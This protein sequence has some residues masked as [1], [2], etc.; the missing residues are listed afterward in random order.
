LSLSETHDLTALSLFFRY[1]FLLPSVDRSILHWASRHRSPHM[2]PL[3]SEFPSPEDPPLSALSSF[4]TLYP[5]HP[6]STTSPLLR[7]FPSPFEKKTSFF[8]STFPFFRTVPCEGCFSL[9]SP[10]F[11]HSPPPPPPVDFPAEPPNILRLPL[12]SFFF[13]LGSKHCPLTFPP[14]FDFYSFV[15]I[16]QRNVAQS[17]LLFLFTK[18]TWGPLPLSSLVFCLWLPYLLSLQFTSRFSG[19]VFS[20]FQPL[21]YPRAGEWP[22]SRVLP[23]SRFLFNPIRLSASD[24]GTV[25]LL[26]GLERCFVS[27][28]PA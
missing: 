22:F 23:L 19:P 20:I 11:F 5:C 15:M 8:F 17:S 26:M 12:K 10:P 1:F 9:W 7:S 3:F 4:F 6:P 13:L 21:F 14:G 25:V 24:F 18:K 27:F 2:T 16:P 28:F